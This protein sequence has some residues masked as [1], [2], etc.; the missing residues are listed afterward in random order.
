MASDPKRTAL[1]QID[2]LFQT[3]S[4]TG[5]DEGQLLDR[6]VADRDELAFEALVES[7]G[8]MVLGV[9]RRWLADPHDVND[10]FQA[11]FLILVR[12]A[13][14]LRDVNR[15][16]P[17]LHG[18]AYRVAARARADTLRSTRAG[19]IGGPGRTR[20]RHPRPRPAG[21]PR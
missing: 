19:A 12:K 16:G 8:P 9:C 21:P 18:V 3:G 4:V 13:R 11:T 14:S 1:Q 2:R 15:L 5:L 17:W 6:F 10:A 20:G 7:H